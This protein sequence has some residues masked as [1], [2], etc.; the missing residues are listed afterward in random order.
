MAGNGTGEDAGA[1]LRMRARRFAGVE[2][3]ENAVWPPSDSAGGTAD[4]KP[5]HLRVDRFAMRL[6]RLR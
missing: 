4:E 2:L 1:I 5:L 3:P 6:R